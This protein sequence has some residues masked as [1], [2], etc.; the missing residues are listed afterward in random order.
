[1]PPDAPHGLCPRCLFLAGGF[2]NADTPPAER[3]AERSSD[4]PKRIGQYDIL[5]PLGEG[6]MARVLRARQHGSDHDVAL[7]ILR[8]EWIG[9]EDAVERFRVAVEIAG[10]LEHPNL[11]RIYDRSGLYEDRPYYTMQLAAGGTLADERNR[12]R[13]RDAP[14][15]AK[16]MIRIA[17]AVQFAHE[18]GVLH[19]DLKPDN[20]LLDLSDRPYVTDFMAKRIDRHAQ[21]RPPKN[22]SA[23][24]GA[25]RYMA[26]EH[27]AGEGA[28]TAGDVYGLGAIFYELL[29]GH[30]PID[31]GSLQEAR[32]RHQTAVIRRPSKQV[33]GLSRELEA[34]CMSALHKDPSHRPSAAV[35]AQSLERVLRD[36]APLH[37]PTPRHRRL[38][39]WQRRH[40]LLAISAVLGTLALLAADVA[41]FTGALSQRD[42]LRN[43]VLRG[44]ATLASAQAQIVFSALEKYG[45]YTVRGA[46][47]PG[48][49]QL[50]LSQ[51]LV[52]DPPLALRD[53]Q[54]RAAFGPDSVFLLNREGVLVARGLSIS[55]A[56]VGKNYA[57]RDYFKCA[58]AL[59]RTSKVS[60]I[61]PPYR[62]EVHNSVQ[63]AFS[64]PVYDAAGNWLGV[65]V[66]SK[67][68][69][70]T[71]AD[72]DIDDLNGSGQ[73]TAVFGARGAERSR[74]GDATHMI[75][76]FHRGLRGNEER[77]L[78]PS[79][80]RR[81]LR[82]F[83]LRNDGG[84]FLLVDARPI[85]DVDYRDP[86]ADPRER[87]LAALAPI[88]RTGYV[89]AVA[90]PYQ[91]ALEPSQRLI[92]LLTLY[93]GLL[94]LGFLVIA[95]IAVWTSLRGTSS[96]DAIDAN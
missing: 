12:R 37:P 40:P 52:Q 32:E 78:S 42:E 89:V 31:V 70:R 91:R 7:R 50:L 61:S 74:P 84:H 16:L 63:F 71:I 4:D 60:C 73:T 82:E 1:V 65:L 59:L 5:E 75:A 68:G 19:R 86:L 47:D 20:I 51:E 80:A 72:V 33:P 62:S 85:E 55:E 81:L 15:A 46:A 28:T 57:F 92:D 54:E 83:K 48:I 24:V 88:G 43:A 66:M 18:H 77:A 87:W 95:A 8:R 36:E 25:P 45:Q 64:A 29:T 49:Q 34:V 6:G 39:L 69:T 90:T 56:F 44:D 67:N 53:L 41:M 11:I 93:G 9:C 26:P 76:V 96:L 79:L 3:R 2:E 13:F 23:I 14:R 10:R 30:P 38:L 22:P 21:L 58:K 94:N 27:A 17:H 35:F